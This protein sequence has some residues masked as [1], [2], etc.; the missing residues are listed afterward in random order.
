MIALLETLLSASVELRDGRSVSFRPVGTSDEVRIRD[1][2]IGMSPANLRLRFFT[3]GCDLRR[4]A[5]WAAEADGV[6][7]YGLLATNADAQVVGHALYVCLKD[8]T[9]AEVAVEVADDLHGQGL[10]TVLIS[11][12]AR[13][14]SAAGVTRFVAEVLP[15][16]HEMLAVFSD[17]FDSERRAADGE[18]H[19]EFDTSSWHMPGERFAGPGRPGALVLDDVGLADETGGGAIR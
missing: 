16:N 19:V 12:L 18:V 8:P 17:G 14:A 5:P 11:Q 7:H 13:H 4:M 1:F 15:E 9:R 3:G 10:G 6:K 2:L